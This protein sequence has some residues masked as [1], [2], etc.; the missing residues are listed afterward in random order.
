MRIHGSNQQSHLGAQ[1]RSSCMFDWRIPFLVWLIRNVSAPSRR[2]DPPISCSELM[3][4]PTDKAQSGQRP[5]AC[6]KCPYTT[7]ER[8][9]LIRHQRTHTSTRPFACPYCDYR[10]AQS[11]GLVRHKAAR[12]PNEVAAFATVAAVVATAAVAGASTSSSSV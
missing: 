10:S 9:A 6:D 8:S 7:A 12:H 4:L 1:A 5:F 2:E 11:C 3:Y